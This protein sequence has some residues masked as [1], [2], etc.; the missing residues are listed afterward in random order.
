MKP[1][2]RPYHRFGSLGHSFII[3]SLDHGDQSSSLFTLHSSLFT[4][5]LCLARAPLPN[6]AWEHGVLN[7][8]HITLHSS[9]GRKAS[10]EAAPFPGTFGRSKVPR[11]KLITIHFKAE[12]CFALNLSFFP[13][14]GQ[15]Q[16]LGRLV[17]S[18]LAQAGNYQY[19]NGHDIWQHSDDFLSLV[20]HVHTCAQHAESA[21]QQ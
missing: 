17:L 19:Q 10:P 7:Y 12:Q 14:I 18:P 6:R 2:N 4:G 5:R 9:L 15:S 16:T 8:S 21:E 13:E 11:E 1:Y 3:R 20:R